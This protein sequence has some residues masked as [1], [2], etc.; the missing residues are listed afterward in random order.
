MC[1]ENVFS[2]PCNKWLPR[3]PVPAL[4]EL[5]QLFNFVA[6]KKKPFVGRRINS[7]AAA[8]GL[9]RGFFWDNIPLE[10][11]GKLLRSE[12]LLQA[13]SVLALQSA[14]RKLLLE[15]IIKGRVKYY[16]SANNYAIEPQKN[17]NYAFVIMK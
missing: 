2:Y 17:F 9:Q 10:R 15:L 13:A 1:F 14:Q 7:Y 5:A 16:R 8:K 6:G 3:Y 4:R 11:S 12:N